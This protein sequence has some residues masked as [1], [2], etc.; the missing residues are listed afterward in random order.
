MNASNKKIVILSVHDITSYYKESCINI[1]QSLSKLNICSYTALI[2]PFWYGQYKNNDKKLCQIL[3]KAQ[4]KGAELALH[5]YTHKAPVTRFE[6]YIMRTTVG[7][8]EFAYCTKEEAL[9]RI[10]LGKQM[11]EQVFA[12]RPKGFVP[13]MW[14]LNHNVLDALKE[15][16][17]LYTTTHNRIHWI[18]KEKSMYCWG[19][20]F[21]LGNNAIT[22][23][24]CNRG[25]FFLLNNQ[26]SGVIRLTLHPL[27][28]KRG[29]LPMQLKL[30]KNLMNK[31]FCIQSYEKYLGDLEL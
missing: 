25:Y 7:E 5:G 2:T 14:K 6:K 23:H 19:Y 28:V 17:F 10:S 31:G 26:K 13:P 15:Q 18:A 24:L 4:K 30:I 1:L 16:G 3:K 27:D 8:S 9:N 12:T 29:L 20:C 11:F 21:D 22:N